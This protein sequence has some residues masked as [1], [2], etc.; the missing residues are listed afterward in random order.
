MIHH[1]M[2]ERAEWFRESGVSIFWSPLA[3]FE[4]GTMSTAASY[5]ANKVATAVS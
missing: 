2:C 5:Q 1:S 4:L 3:F